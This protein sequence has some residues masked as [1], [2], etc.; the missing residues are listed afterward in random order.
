MKFKIKIYDIVQESNYS[1][2]TP[3][4]GRYS[5][6]KNKNLCHRKK[7]YSVK[8]NVIFEKLILVNSGKRVI[9]N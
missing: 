9:I 2:K 6:M 5:A 4:N 7:Y 3:K 1:A 8:I